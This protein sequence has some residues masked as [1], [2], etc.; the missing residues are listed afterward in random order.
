MEEDD[1][2]HYLIYQVLGISTTEG[3]QIDVYQNT[4][5]FLYKYA[6]AFLEEAASLCLYCNNLEGGKTTVKNK[7]TTMTRRVFW[8]AFFIGKTINAD[9]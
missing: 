5:R 9:C 1:N 7:T 6:G 4:G 3:K 2:S 8:K